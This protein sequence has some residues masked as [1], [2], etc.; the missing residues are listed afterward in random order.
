M[1]LGK[2]ARAQQ[3]HTFDIHAAPRQG[4]VC[5]REVE[6]R[7]SRP[8]GP[9]PG[10]TTGSPPSL[11]WSFSRRLCR[12]SGDIAWLK[13]PE[14]G[15]CLTQATTRCRTRGW[16]GLSPESG[17]VRGA[18][19]QRA[20]LSRASVSTALAARVS[21]PAMRARRILGGA[22]GAARV[23]PLRASRFADRMAQ[24]LKT[25]ASRCRVGFERCGG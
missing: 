24:S 3:E 23:R 12:S 4:L 18:C 8:P 14:V 17:R 15:I 16:G 1:V 13:R 22:H 10:P 11:F 25:P 5:R 21:L 6:A 7:L 9:A 20:G 2:I 19:Y